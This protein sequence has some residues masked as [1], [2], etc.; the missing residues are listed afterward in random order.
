M[1]L[2]QRL[3]A[4]TIVAAA[5]VLA[6]YALS[7][8]FERNAPPL[9]SLPDQ[10]PA[11]GAVLEEGSLLVAK[12]VPV[13]PDPAERVALE[14]QQ[15]A[16]GD[17]PVP[18]TFKEQLKAVVLSMQNHGGVSKDRLY[19]TLDNVDDVARNLAFNPDGKMLTAEQRI[20]LAALVK[21]QNDASDAAGAVYGEAS[22]QATLRALQMDQVVRIEPG[23][24][25]AENFRRI[26]EAKDLLSQRFGKEL[27]DWRCTQSFRTESGGSDGESWIALTYYT[28]H[29]SPAA[30]EA[31]AAVM[32]V[33]AERAP[34]YRRF[35]A[36]LP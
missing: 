19:R 26:N 36:N 22:F 1:Q 17:V 9:P 30:F 32:K 4:A 7:W 35:F 12:E 18:K 11:S 31:A 5:L 15:P 6:I 13:A 20:E 14:G 34:R 16:T 8:P 25:A 27:V 3:T 23:R 33:G 2:R 21:E 29:Q 28:L 10:P 24:T